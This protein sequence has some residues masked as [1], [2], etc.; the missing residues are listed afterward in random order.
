LRRTAFLLA[1][2]LL[3]LCARLSFGQLGPEQTPGQ[4][5]NFSVPLTPGDFEFIRSI[6][7]GM[8][9]GISFNFAPPGARA[10]GM[11]NSFIGLA[12]DAT[13]GAANPAGLT[14]IEKPEC[15]VHFRSTL[16]DEIYA[17]FLITS[18]S[19]YGF[20]TASVDPYFGRERATYLSYLSYVRPLRSRLTFT[21]YYYR[22]IDFVQDFSGVRDIRRPAGLTSLGPEGPGAL[23]EDDFIR[24]YVR[25]RLSMVE[26]NAGAGLGYKLFKNFSVGGTARLS[27]LSVSAFE[28]TTDL[29]TDANQTSNRG[30]NYSPN[31]D[32]D[33]FVVEITRTSKI[34]DTAFKLSFNAGFLWSPSWRFSLGGVYRYGPGY[35]LRSYESLAG[36]TGG[37]ETGY[38]TNPDVDDDRDGSP[39]DPFDP[40]LL[41]STYTSAGEDGNIWVHIPIHI[42]DSYGLGMKLRVT[43][44]LVV[45]CDVLRLRYS[46]L[47][48]L[49]LFEETYAPVETAKHSMNDGTEYHAGLEYAIPSIPIFLRAG[50]YNDP[51]HDGVPSNMPG[52]FPLDTAQI[53]KTF[54]VGTV[55]NNR[56]QVDTG[57][58]IGKH[59]KDIALSLVYTF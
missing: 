25:A 28:F 42:P 5:I 39:F 59:I 13:A 47:R 6:P 2:A 38:R 55:I 51:D 35:R 15:S 22:D 16:Y 53:I 56:V 37:F 58:L 30:P 36:A 10:T 41:H 57:F 18:D 48:S 33:D 11:G 45:A 34:D 23:L 17:P 54:G 19:L 3:L 14:Q 50:V 9:Q 31:D 12:D 40:A 49:R 21:G 29:D 44:R 8:R 1:G 26:D 24:F 46:E 32:R 7:S 4:P 43:D 27:R 52:V 20:D